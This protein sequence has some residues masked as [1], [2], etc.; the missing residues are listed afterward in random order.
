M[1]LKIAFTDREAEQ[2][3]VLGFDALLLASPRSGWPDRHRIAVLLSLSLAVPVRAGAAS[4][5]GCGG[6]EAVSGRAALRSG[7]WVGFRWRCG[8]RGRSGDAFAGSR[9]RAP[10]GVSSRPCV[11]HLFGLSSVSL[12][13]AVEGREVLE[14]ALEGDGEDGLAADSSSFLAWSIRSL[15]TCAARTSR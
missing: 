12:E 1:T 7:A 15:R 9:R 8:A 10:L 2:R 11:R 6:G 5:E 3:E 14:A 4:S 13:G